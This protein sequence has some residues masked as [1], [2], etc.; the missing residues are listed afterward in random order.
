MVALRLWQSPPLVNIPTL[1]F[2]SFLSPKDMLQQSYKF[3]SV[4]II[5]R[6]YGSK[7]KVF[8]LTKNFRGDKYAFVS[9]EDILL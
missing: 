7:G 6:F 2:S 8:S 1:M 9:P 3:H 4:I 5:Q